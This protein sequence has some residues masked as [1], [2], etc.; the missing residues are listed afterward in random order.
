MQFLSLK[1]T[2]L[3]VKNQIGGTPFHM[4]GQLP[5]AIGLPDS[6]P[7]LEP[8]RESEQGSQRVALSMPVADRKPE[9]P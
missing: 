9:R 7:N 1:E 6:R 8:P 2:K 5:A 3:N 4:A